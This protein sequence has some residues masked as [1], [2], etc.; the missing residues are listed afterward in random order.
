MPHT[1][2]AYGEN[3]NL[4]KILFYASRDI[5]KYKCLSMV[6]KAARLHA[7][8]T[9]IRNTLKKI[10]NASKKGEIEEYSSSGSQK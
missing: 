2:I 1:E 7:K 8:R 6:K 9:C 10:Q 5:S 3:P 4:G